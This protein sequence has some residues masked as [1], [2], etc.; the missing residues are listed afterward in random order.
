MEINEARFNQ[1]CPAVDAI[2]IDTRERLQQSE[3]QVDKGIKSGT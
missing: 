1:A 3:M 2:S